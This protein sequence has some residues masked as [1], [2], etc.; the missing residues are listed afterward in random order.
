MPLKEVE[1]GVDMDLSKIVESEQK[2]RSTTADQGLEELAASME[3]LGQIH[4]VSLLIND[5]GK[6]ELINGHRRFAAAS[7]HGFRALRANIYRAELEEGED[8]EFMI[9]QHLHAANLTESLLP[10]ERARMF[11]EMLREL[12]IDVPKLAQLLDGETEAS[13]METLQ[14]LSISEDVLKMVEDNADRFSEANLRVL[15]E[16]ASPTKRAW[17]LNPDEQ[18]KVAREIVEQKDKAAV[19]DPRKFEKNVRAVVTAR[20]KEAT[21]KK[22]DSRTDQVKALYRALTRLDEAVKDLDQIQ[23]ESVKDIDP[24]DKGEAIRRVYEVVDRLTQLADGRLTKM[25]VRTGAK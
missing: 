11:D 6:Y 14:Y 19:R 20:R 17:R 18:M 10:I 21:E 12:D 1:L 3:R 22:T 16:Y 2:W 4:A 7:R 25:A 15:A 8:L 9:A 13:I 23:Y 24:K 5:D